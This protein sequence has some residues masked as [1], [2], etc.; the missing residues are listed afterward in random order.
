M[1]MCPVTIVVVAL[2]LSV[3]SAPAAAQPDGIAPTQ[4]DEFVPLESLPPSD[5]LP[6]A[7]LLIGA[8]ALVWIA[9]L[10]FVGLTWRR[11]AR[12]EDEFSRISKSQGL[13]GG[14]GSS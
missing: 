4:V 10:G 13:G 8:Y 1:R 9:V 7:P 6:A 12:L 5:Q 14:V 3:V 11:V 2:A